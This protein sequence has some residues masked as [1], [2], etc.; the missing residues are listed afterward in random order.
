MGFEIA[1]STAAGLLLVFAALEAACDSPARAAPHVLVRLTTGI[2]GAGF[3]PLGQALA[4]IYAAGLRDTEVV[5]Q[6]SS[7]SVVNVT[8]LQAG[9]A[10][11]GL[12]F[13]DVAYI[14]FAG[15]LDPQSRSFD[16]L[17][18]IAV[19]QLTPLHLVV[20]A[21]TDID[22]LH[23]LRGR[24]IGLGPPGSGTAMTARLVLDAFGV[25][26]DTF[27]GQTLPFNDAA[28]RL[29]GGSLDAMF[30]NASYPAESVRAATQ[31]GARLLPIGGK[32]V[33]DL[34]HSYPFL[35]LTSVPAGV[36][37]GH[38]RPVHTIGI[39]ALLICRSDL[40]ED[41]VYELTRRFF[42][43]LPELSRAHESLRLMD[44]EQAPATPI[45]L[46]AGAARYYRE[47]ELSR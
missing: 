19:L 17:R 43:R 39:D 14:A 46:H 16:R 18:G 30:V 25:G 36:Y 24:R 13:A 41:F 34:R 35:R 47:R 11:V 22:D 1:R 38:P 4:H 3:H 27:D 28:A 31:A 23:D 6:E 2:P 9:D 8:R 32:A 10:D 12:A 26:S 44:L 40:D 15:E 7:G 45:P 5:V 21:G 37:P 29:I 20:R 42:Q 33:D